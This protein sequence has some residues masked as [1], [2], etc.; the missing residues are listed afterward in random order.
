MQMNRGNRVAVRCAFLLVLAAIMGAGG[1]GAAPIHAVVL[2]EVSEPTSI[3]MASIA[4]LAVATILRR[5]KNQ[6]GSSQ[7]RDH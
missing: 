3:V 4:M 2:P 7:T 5:R 6:P 1:I